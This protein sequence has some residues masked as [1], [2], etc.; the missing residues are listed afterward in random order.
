MKKTF[1]KPFAKKYT[2]NAK[3]S[4]VSSIKFDDGTFSVQFHTIHTDPANQDVI[5][6]EKQGCYDILDGYY[7]I[8]DGPYTTSSFAN[9]TTIPNVMAS[10]DSFNTWYIDRYNSDH[11][12]ANCHSN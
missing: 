9:N 3:E 10:Y 1:V 11:G 4:I 7:P 8:P 5:W 12:I 6:T 2:L